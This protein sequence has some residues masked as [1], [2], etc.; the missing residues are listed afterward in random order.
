M[1][2]L[3]MI[4]RKQIRQAKDVCFKTHGSAEY[5]Q[6]MA[7]E[8]NRKPYEWDWSIQEAGVPI[9]VFCY[10]Q[11]ILLGMSSPANTRIQFYIDK[12]LQALCTEVTPDF[13]RSGKWHINQDN[14]LTEK[15]EGLS[16]D[17]WLAIWR[18]SK[19]YAHVI[20]AGHVEWPDVTAFTVLEGGSDD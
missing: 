10:G 9:H 1:G 13:T 2:V 6:C 14:P 3:L 19:L 5:D 8:L 18:R 15:P 12:D 7:D 16:D 4:T 17:A 11:A 20:K